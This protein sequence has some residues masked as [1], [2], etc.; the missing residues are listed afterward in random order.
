MAPQ[1]EM[2]ILQF[3]LLI[4][5]KSNNLIIPDD[6]IKSRIYLIRGQKIMLDK[7]LSELYGVETKQLKRAVRRNIKRFPADFMFELTKKEFKNLRNQIDT[8]SWGGTCYMP[9]AFTEQGVAMLSSV[10]NSEQAITVNIRIIRIFTKMR[11]LLS[12][13][14]EILKK[15][16]QIEKKDVEQDDKIMLIFEYLKQFEEDKQEELNQK[17]RTK[18]GYKTDDD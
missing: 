15:L 3:K 1:V 12:S 7:D 16:E 6:I 4:M 17:N 5:D 13:H 9:M 18:I 8:S 10:L 11:E 14:K 2:L